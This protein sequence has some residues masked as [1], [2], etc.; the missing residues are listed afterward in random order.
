MILDA[1]NYVFVVILIG[2]CFAWITLMKSMVDS[3]RYTPILDK[4]HAKTH[5]IPRVSIILPARN[6]E[7]FIA[8]CLDSLIS[9][10]YPNYEIITIDDSSEDSTGEIISKYA[11][12]N[13]KVI[14]VTAGPKPEG[15]MG[16]NWACM[17]GYKR[18][19][20]E[21]LLFT[22]ADTEFEKNVISLAVS[23][24]ESLGLDALTV[25]PKMVC[26]DVWT[27]ITL[28]VISTFLH[29]RFSAIR[30]NDPTKKT[31][32]FFGSFFIIRKTT[33]DSVG[34]HEG[35]KHEI[36][37]DGALG[38]KVKEGG[39][40]MKMVRGD[41]LIEAVWARDWSTLWNALK[42]LMIP[43]FLQ[44]GRIAVG[45][46][47]AVLFLLFMPYV[48][49]LYSIPFAASS[50]SFSAVF[51]SSVVSSAL[52]FS[53]CVIDARALQIKMKYAICAPLGSL[54]VVGG[55]LVGLIQAKSSSAVSWRGR[56]YSMKDHTPDFINI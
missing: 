32:Y 5:H 52:L 29:T 26:L 18:A 45:I 21:L 51:V 28:P 25:I 36:I 15:W 7:G 3:F 40:R 11:E 50:A 17:D 34:T 42:R 30:V 43:L 20:G 14:H 44:N 56:T 33:Y 2:I 16:K 6:E 8:K 41:H 9:Q 1:I 46:F 23:H 12:K 47:F 48:F 13:S 37:E 27:K 49:L 38:K 24:L 53:A 35:V 19:T 31:G 39:F 10:D 22:D 55:F 4:F 54:V